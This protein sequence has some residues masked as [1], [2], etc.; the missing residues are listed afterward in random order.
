MLKEAASRLS[1]GFVVITTFQ[2]SRLRLL[3]RLVCSMGVLTE[4][5]YLRPLLLDP[6]LAPSLGFCSPKIFA[7]NLL[8]MLACAKAG[9]FTMWK[10]SAFSSTLQREVGTKGLVKR[11]AEIEI[12]QN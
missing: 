10:C 5:V 4:S 6:S 9:G 1:Q 2:T 12:I 8:G 7:N 3:H 11:Y